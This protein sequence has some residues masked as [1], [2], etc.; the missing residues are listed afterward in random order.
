MQQPR[1]T[2]QLDRLIEQLTAKDG[3]YLQAFLDM[4]NGALKQSG[5]APGEYA[6]ALNCIVGKPL[7]LVNMG[8]SLELSMPPNKNQSTINDKDPERYLLHQKNG[9]SVDD[10]YLFPIKLGDSHREYDGL[11]GYFPVKNRTK[12][13]K[14]QDSGNLPL[15]DK[16][17]LTKLYTYFGHDQKPDAPGPSYP[18]LELNNDSYPRLPPYWLDPADYDKSTLPVIANTAYASDSYAALQVFAAVLDPFQPV[19]GYSSFLPIRELKLL[20]WTWQQALNHM[21]AFFHMGP[22]IVTR[23]V[24]GFDPSCELRADYS[25]NGEQRVYDK[26]TVDVLPTSVSEWNWLQPYYSDKPEEQ[27]TETPKQGVEKTKF[28]P[29]KGR[30]DTRPRFEKGPYTA[31]EGYLQMQ[32]SIIATD[33]ESKEGT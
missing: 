33:D 22:L 20:D 28:M 4:I 12:S 9:P 24:P 16:F 14:P 32:K 8:W 2:A 23:D 21:T 10:S 27:T 25:L 18:L 15:N 3:V 1:A 13:P 17:D 30:M 5:P 6:E 26:Q 11:V 7:A 19:H 29:V 31:I